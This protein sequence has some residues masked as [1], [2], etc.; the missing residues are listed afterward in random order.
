MHFAGGRGGA[1]PAP[2]G[3]APATHGYVLHLVTQTVLF[4]VPYNPRV[5]L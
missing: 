5:V 2:P 4:Y 1:C 3:M